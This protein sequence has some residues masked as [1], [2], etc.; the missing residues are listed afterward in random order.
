MKCPL[1]CDWTSGRLIGVLLFVLAG[2]SSGGGEG[3]GGLVVEEVTIS[4]SAIDAIEVDEGE[5]VVLR[6]RASVAGTG[7]PLEYDWVLLSGADGVALGDTESASLGFVAPEVSHDT[8]LVFQVT[9]SVDGFIPSGI[10]GLP[11][12][13]AYVTIRDTTDYPP[14]VDIGPDQTLPSQS[15]VLLQGSGAQDDMGI[16]AFEWRQLSGPVVDIV[17]NSPDQRFTLPVVTSVSEIGLEL[18]VTD[19]IGQQSTE[20]VTITVNPPENPVAV[21]KVFSDTVI[22]GQNFILNGQSSTDELQIVRFH[23]QQVAGQ[24]VALDSVDKP[25]VAFMAPPTGVDQALLFSLTVT[26]ATGLSATTMQSV[27]LRPVNILPVALVSGPLRADEQTTV[28]LDGSASSDADGT[29]Q[30]FQWRQ[31]DGPTATILS[32]Q[33]G[34]LTIALPETDRVVALLFQL[35]VI[36]DRGD[37]NQAQQQIL[38][39]P[40]NEPPLLEVTGP[41]NIQAKH[42]GKIT[43]T[44][45]DSDGQIHDIK[46]VQS[47]GPET[48]LAPAG[49]GKYTFIAPEQDVAFQFT[50]IDNEGASTVQD[51]AIAVTANPSAAGLD[52]FFPIPGSLYQADAISVFGSAQLDGESD[53][54]VIT[55]SV[56][57]S[58]LQTT[59]DEQG[60][61]RVDGLDLV[62]DQ[63][64]HTITVTAEYSDNTVSEKALQ[65]VKHPAAI[66]G[67]RRI[68]ADCEKNS[69]YL[70]GLAEVLRLSCDGQVRERFMPDS[71]APISY[72]GAV[73]LALADI[74]GDR[75]LIINNALGLVRVDLQTRR[76]EQIA[77]TDNV[78]TPLK[79]LRLDVSGATALVQIRRDGYDPLVLVDLRSGSYRELPQVSN[80]LEELNISESQLGDF[81]FD[82][83]QNS[84]YVIQRGRGV[85]AIE[86]TTL[87]YTLFADFADIGGSVGKLQFLTEGAALVGDFLANSLVKLDPEMGSQQLGDDGLIAELGFRDFTYSAY[88]NSVYF[89]AA[90][91]ARAIVKYNLSSPDPSVRYKILTDDKPLSGRALG[92]M[93]QFTQEENSSIVYTAGTEGVHQIDLVTGKTLQL[94]TSAQLPI[95]L[96]GLV[97]SDELAYNPRD[98]TLNIIGGELADRNLRRFAVMDLSG[99][100]VFGPYDI[101]SKK[102]VHLLTD[103]NSGFTYVVDNVFRSDLPGFH[104]NSNFYQLDFPYQTPSSKLLDQRIGES[105]EYDFDEVILAASLNRFLAVDSDTQSLLSLSK[106]TLVTLDSVDLSS[107]GENLRAPRMAWSTTD[108]IVYLHVRTDQQTSLVIVDLESQAVQTVFTGPE[109]GVMKSAT[110]E[111]FVIND[112]RG[113]ILFRQYQELYALDK[114]TGDQIVLYR[115]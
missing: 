25:I 2:C 113:L 79:I 63:T 48:W 38:L 71:D 67:A 28:E 65:I 52:V 101:G 107:L 8:V 109:L 62:P 18:T 108:G 23:W 1:W 85:L 92:E 22:E 80:L 111:K 46:V 102:T 56:G 37:Q 114:K 66:T 30:P 95:R 6:A 55:V 26:D 60:L 40:I 70:L 97:Y 83:A 16:T 103:E 45:D 14:Q 100:V 27:L 86:L 78:E 61:W 34:R 69:L 72:E 57:S 41:E 74:D 99:S 90:N 88:D 43:V 35:T 53:Q 12:Q 59:S 98:N 115:Y 89:I 75:S 91:S 77:L 5:N 94:A 3:S 36:D 24:T 4:L 32:E 42:V 81:H 58:R 13:R 51:L 112:H 33:Q 110:P 44:A 54:A 68:V 20:Q 87:S 50:A 73:R 21:I 47:S 82:A 49:G 104:H 76:A 106:D 29:L 31:L 64:V 11:R 93:S 9:V 10:P 84:L 17:G 39:Q 15:E 19:T 105:F 96:D 7:K